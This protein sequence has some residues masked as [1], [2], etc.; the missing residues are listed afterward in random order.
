M[1]ILPPAMGWGGNN[2]SKM[3]KVSISYSKT[4]SHVQ[5]RLG[6]LK[7]T[8]VLLLSQSGRIQ[9]RI[10]ILLPRKI[11]KIVADVKLYNI[12]NTYDP[13][14]HVYNTF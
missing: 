14:M 10:S 12:I 9:N 5:Q 8:N 11:F 13:Y 7:I 4:A 2:L 1:V 6:I 3:S